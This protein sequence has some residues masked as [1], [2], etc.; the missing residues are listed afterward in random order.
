MP[1]FYKFSHL[2]EDL[3]KSFHM[4]VIDRVQ[5][6]HIRSWVKINTLDICLGVNS[7]FGPVS[8]PCWLCLLLN[9]PFGTYTIRQFGTR[10]ELKISLESDIGASTPIMVPWE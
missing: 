5:Y 4:E 10:R 1:C 8:Q 7:P 9:I 2:I 6:S 3:A